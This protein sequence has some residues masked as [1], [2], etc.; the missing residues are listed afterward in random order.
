MDESSVK[1]RDELGSVRIGY[2]WDNDVLMHKLLSEAGEETEISPTYQI[3]LPTCY[4]PALL[5]FAH[6]HAIAIHFGINKT[7]LLSR[8]NVLAPLLSKRK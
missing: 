3:V 5:K 4:C 1:T 7:F 2:Y 8:P 6:E